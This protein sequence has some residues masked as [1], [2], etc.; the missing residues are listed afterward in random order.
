MV[1]FRY[2]VVSIIAVF[3]A[4]AVGIVL[5]NAAL[6]DPV[7]NTLRGSISALSKDKR[8]LEGDVRDLQGRVSDDNSFVTSVAPQLVR[9][10]LVDQRVLL[11][12]TPDADPQ[13][14][15]AL[16]QVLREAGATVSGRVRLGKDLLEATPS[17]RLVDVVGRTVPGAVSLPP[18]TPQLRAAV[19]LAGSLLHRSGAPSPEAPAAQKILSAY[20]SADLLDVEQ[21]TAPPGPATLTVLL[22]GSPHAPDDDDQRARTAAAV[23]LARAFD[24]RS[25]GMVVAGPADSVQDG[26]VLRAVRADP[27]AAREVSSVDLADSPMGGVLVALAVAEQRQGRTGS[28]GGGPKVSAAVPTPTPTPS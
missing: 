16:Q 13:L 22:T 4:L 7:V 9:G 5:G 14:A 2:H 23:T 1:D 19:E 20:V 3:L 17:T 27:V 12:S 21:A 26:G 11:V 28:Y 25:D 8:G 18:G 10:T 24:E 15:G 6:N